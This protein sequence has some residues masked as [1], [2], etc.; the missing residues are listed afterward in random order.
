[1]VVVTH[2]HSAR[3][4]PARWWSEHSLNH[5]TTRQAI[6]AG[7]PWVAV[8]GILAAGGCV[9]GLAFPLL[10]LAVVVALWARGRRG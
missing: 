9:W 6:D 3:S 4:V 8:A 2:E 10:M 7:W 5:P 1:M